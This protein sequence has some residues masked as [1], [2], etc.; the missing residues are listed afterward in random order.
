VKDEQ[1]P[2]LYQDASST[3][4]KSQ[5]MF[6]RFL[7]GNLTS[8]LLLTL[9]E[10]V[11][12]ESKLRSAV[13]LVLLLS[14][15]CCIFWLA[16]KKPQE[17]WYNARALAESVKTMTWRFVTKSEPYSGKSDEDSK[18]FVENL[19]K[20]LNDNSSLGLPAPKVDQV[21]EEMKRVRNQTVDERQKYYL[22]FRVI[23]QLTW[24][25]NKA[26]WN[27]TRS[28][29]WFGFIVFLHV[30]AILCSLLGV[31]DFVNGSSFFA[32]LLALAS[33]SMAWLQAKRFQDLAASYSLTAHDISL[34]KEL[35]QRNMTGQEFSDFVGDAEN[36]FSREHTQ[37]RARRDVG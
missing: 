16:L 33:S 18:H 17:A 22:K 28:K 34:I 7:A 26:D 4:C 21:S 9:V 35:G 37:W 23:D 1:Y 3:A 8:L 19:A 30:L 20:L 10:I 32:L 15:L 25:K 31:L 5:K 27:A 11:G 12:S 24:Y 13:N 29:Y 36:A 6:F 2:A 14:S